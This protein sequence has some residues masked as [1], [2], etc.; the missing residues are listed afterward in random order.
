[1]PRLRISNAYKDLLGEE[2]QGSEVKDYLK[3]K[4][5][6]AK[7][8]IKC[9]HQRQETLFNILKQITIHQ[10]DFLLKGVAGLKP[11]T[12]NDVAALVKVHE[13]TVS[14]AV[15]NKYVETPW[16]VYPIKFFFTSGFVTDEGQVLSNT[17]IKEQIEDLI[18]REDPSKPY[19]DSEI[20]TVLKE[21]GIDIARR[22][23][24]KYRLES[25]ILPSNLRKKS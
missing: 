24:A 22:T 7:F 1:L 23:V 3:D 14:R 20:V 12:M 25:G 19:S 8:M 2:K 10:R 4:I 17:T 21:K 18:G 13:T 9:I 6:S 16:G 5:R 15:A 11:L